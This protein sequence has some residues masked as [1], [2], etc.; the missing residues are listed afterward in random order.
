MSHILAK[1]DNFA[2]SPTV[3]GF[4]SDSPDTITRGFDFPISRLYGT[5]PKVFTESP[6]PMSR[7]LGKTTILRMRQRWADFSQIFA[8]YNYEGFPMCQFYGFTEI[9]QNY[10]PESSLPMSRILAKN[11]NSARAP[12]VGGFLSD[13]RPLQLRGIPAFPILR[14]YGAFSKTIVLNRHFR[15]VTSWSKTTI[16]RGRQRWADF[17]HIFAH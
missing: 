16:L 6:L 9:P 2:P 7:I 15:R 1:N 4:R 11:D 3:G 5:L 8:H 14:A 17:C 10:F 12:T 13:F